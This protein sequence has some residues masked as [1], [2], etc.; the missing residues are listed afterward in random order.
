MLKDALFP[1]S[2]DYVALMKVFVFQ[3]KESLVPV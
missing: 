1:V 2:C 3:L